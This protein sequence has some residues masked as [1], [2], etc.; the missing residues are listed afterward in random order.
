MSFQSLLPFEFAIFSTI[1]DMYVGLKIQ[2]KVHIAGNHNYKNQSKHEKC[3]E[4]PKWSGYGK[5]H[6]WQHHNGKFK[7]FQTFFLCHSYYYF[8]YR[9]KDCISLPLKN[10]QQQWHQ[11]YKHWKAKFKNTTKNKTT[12]TNH[13]FS[14]NKLYFFHS[15]NRGHHKKYT[16]H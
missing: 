6:P 4:A 15:L 7:P 11:N 16:L 9:P 13:Q 14:S 3:V 1:L 2:N 5:H 8:C 12:N 10:W